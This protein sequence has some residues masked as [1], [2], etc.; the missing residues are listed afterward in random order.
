MTK[1]KIYIVDWNQKEVYNK[2]KD[3][4]DIIIQGSKPYPED[5]MNR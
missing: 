5:L 1:P 3:E 2:L 4:F